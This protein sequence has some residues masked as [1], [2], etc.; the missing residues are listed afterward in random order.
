MAERRIAYTVI[1]R[2]LERTHTGEGEAG[3]LLVDGQLI[4]AADPV[5][6]FDLLVDAADRLKLRLPKGSQRA[7]ACHRFAA[8]GRHAVN[9]D[10]TI[11]GP[12]G[13]VMTAAAM[14]DVV[15]EELGADAAEQ[16]RIAAAKRMGVR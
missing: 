3:V 11:K 5:S 1:D 8:Y 6:A 13:Q 10:R 15:A 16:V 9:G 12:R 2:A 14:L 4:L 7:A